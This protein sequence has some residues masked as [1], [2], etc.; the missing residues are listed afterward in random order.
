M[1]SLELSFKGTDLRIKHL[2][3][4]Y[5]NTNLTGEEVASLMKQIADAKLFVKDDQPLYATPVRADIVETTKTALMGGTA[6]EPTPA[7]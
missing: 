1:K 4:K 5:V 3:L 7:A 6:A 2:R